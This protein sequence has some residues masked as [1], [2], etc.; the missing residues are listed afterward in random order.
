MTDPTLCVAQYV[1]HVW[2]TNEPPTR[3]PYS[4][5]SI[6]FTAQPPTKLTTKKQ[7]GCFYL[8]KRQSHTSNG[9]HQEGVFFRKVQRSM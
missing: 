1:Q 3:Q 7:D 4:A 9:R 6:E 2:F 8:A 5:P